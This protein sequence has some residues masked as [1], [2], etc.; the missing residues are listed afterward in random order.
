V[1]C[2]VS[3]QCAGSLMHTYDGR[4]WERKVIVPRAHR[5]GFTGAG[6]EE[7]NNLVGELDRYS[8]SIT[9]TEQVWLSFR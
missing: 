1:G 5:P 2:A 3:G 8:G 4:R 7:V 6:R 9:N